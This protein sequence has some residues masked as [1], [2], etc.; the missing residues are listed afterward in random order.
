MAPCMERRLQVCHL[1]LCCLTA[2]VRARWQMPDVEKTVSAS[3]RGKSK[4]SRSILRLRGA[5]AGASTQRSEPRTDQFSLTQLAS[6]MAAAG[7]DFWT[8]EKLATLLPVFD[9]HDHASIKHGVIEVAAAHLEDLLHVIKRPK[10]QQRQ[11]ELDEAALPPKL[12]EATL[13]E[14][15]AKVK[16]VADCAD[17]PL[18]VPEL[19]LRAAAVDPPT[20]LQS[21][22][23]PAFEISTPMLVMPF[24]QFKQQGRIFK[25]VKAWREEAMTS[26]KLVEYAWVTGG[27]GK[28]KD[29]TLDGTLDI[30][31][32]KVAIFLSHTW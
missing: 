9:V 24:P 5:G 20:S 23:E 28:V 25:S 12:R 30:V 32:G 11:H 19:L 3:S 26:R 7:L 1:L 31:P 27:T 16:E 22:T 4:C 18:T 2:C 8:E 15:L 29:G 10:Q 21:V 14:A 13:Q 17:R 6:M